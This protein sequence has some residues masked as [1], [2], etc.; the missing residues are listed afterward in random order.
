LKQKVA[1]EAKEKEI[2]KLDQEQKQQ[3]KDKARKYV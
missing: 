3:L 1:S 2:A